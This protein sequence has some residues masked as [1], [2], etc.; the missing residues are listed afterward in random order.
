[1]HRRNLGAS[2]T[3][4]PLQGSAAKQPATS[5]KKIIEISNFDAKC[6]V[7]NHKA[8]KVTARVD[9]KQVLVAS[10]EASGDI[11]WADGDVANQDVRDAMDHY[12]ADLE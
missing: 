10:V 2:E 6:V 8:F 5:K 9:G 7:V 3:D 1:M 11:K 4:L 12:I